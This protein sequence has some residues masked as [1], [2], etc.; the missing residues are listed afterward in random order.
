MDFESLGIVFLIVT[1]VIGVALAAMSVGVMLKRPCLRGSCGG[2][3]AHGPDG[4]AISC[5]SCPN[6]R[7]E[8]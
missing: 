4:E 1:A 2:A 8:A 5:A 6:R 3:A 7:T